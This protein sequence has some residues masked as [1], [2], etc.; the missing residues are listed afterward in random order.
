LPVRDGAFGRLARVALACTA[1]VAF[2]AAQGPTAFTAPDGSRFVLLPDPAMPLVHWAI[3]TPTDDPPG[4]QGLSL[5]TM[6]ASLDGT[7]LTGSLDAARERRSLD[8]F[9]DAWRDWMA[10]VGDAERSARVVTGKQELDQLADRAAFRRVLAAL[11][12]HRPEVI[13]RAPF[14]AFVATTTAEALPEFARLLVERREEQALRDLYPYWAETTLRREA[15]LTAD[16]DV[17]LRAEVLAL[18][19]PDHPFARRLERAVPTSPPRAV[20]LATW[21]RTQRPERS[22]HLLLG[23]FDAATVRTA[24]ERAFATTALPP[25]PVSPSPTPRPITSLRRSAVNGLPAPTV[26]I[27]FVLPPA[28]EPLVLEA[29]A[30]WL[31]EGPDAFLC[32]E[33]Q[34]LGRK[35]AT[36]RCDAPWPPTISGRSLFLVQ[37]RDP[38]G[39]DQLAD[40]MTN[41]LRRSFAAPPSA[42][43]M[44]TVL[45][46]MQRERTEAANDPRRL[47]VDLA[48]TAATWPDRPADASSLGAIDPAAIQRLANALF[49]GQPVIVEGRP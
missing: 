16:P 21:Q 36:V 38:A 15:A 18:A 47:A 44:Q 6:R 11:P 40:A 24:L 22:V 41:A 35:D 32:L 33:L 17:A 3:V 19:I 34:R 12:V 45:A 20:A 39:V 8:A 5:A 4:C 48:V 25:A 13:E 27:A 42:A 2:V 7:W 49:A 31:A 10:N 46:A 9:D 26:A 14:C 1:T 43:A 30:R 23:G 37:V 29:L 28:I